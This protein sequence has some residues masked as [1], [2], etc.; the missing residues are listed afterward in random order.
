MSET[1]LDDEEASTD[2][3]LDIAVLS[4][5]TRT[6]LF[7]PSNPRENT[8]I[9]IQ[10]GE[11]RFTT[12]RETLME[13]S[14]YFAT[15]LSGRWNDAEPDGSYFVDGDPDMFVHILRFFRTGTLPVFYDKARGHD[16]SLY[17]ALLAEA[18]YYQVPPL[19]EWLQKQEYLNRV[20]T[21]REASVV[22]NTEALN[23]TTASCEEMEYHYAW[24]AEKIYVCPRRILVHEGKLES[25]GRACEEARGDKGFEYKERS[26]LK[27]LVI[28]KRTIL[29][30]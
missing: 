6:T 16:Y 15:R 5:D 1:S 28:R 27:I 2:S 20:V 19:V 21:N 24:R 14:G 11:R 10:V 4:P 22:N 13:G 23:Q 17:T 18:Q 8:K 3:N 26:A 25:C 7:Q 30:D 29:V 9:H 12:T